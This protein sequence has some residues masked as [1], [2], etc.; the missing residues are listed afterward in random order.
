MLHSLKKTIP[1]LILLILVASVILMG[2]FAEAGAQDIL[3][4]DGTLNLSQWD[5]ETVLHLSGDWDFYWNSF[6]G[7]NALSKNSIPDLETK[8]P[9]VWNGL[10]VDGTQLGGMG[11]ATYRLHVTGAKAGIPLAMRIIPFSAA[12][13]I[14]IDDELVATSGKISTS[15]DGFLPQYVIQTVT[16]TPDSGEFD[17]ILHI[18]NFIYARGGAW[19]PIYFGNSEK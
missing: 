8:F 7:E 9:S 19:N 18:S 15:A 14:Y 1:I 6:L 5:G 10:I 16:F 3:A 11:Y 13:E 12:Y 4:R 17:I 2:L